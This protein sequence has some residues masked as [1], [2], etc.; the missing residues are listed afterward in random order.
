MV[1]KMGDAAT[2]AAYLVERGFWCG[3]KGLGA[4]ERKRFSDRVV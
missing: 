4:M 1:E 3:G 2:L